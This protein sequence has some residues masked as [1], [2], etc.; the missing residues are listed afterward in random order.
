MINLKRPLVFILAGLLATPLFGQRTIADFKL[1]DVV[2]DK[3]VALTDF[4]QQRGLV[5]IFTGNECP[6]DAH[7]RNRLRA[8]IQNYGERVSFLLIN[9]YTEPDEDTGSMKAAFAGWQLTAPYLADKE[10]VAL[11]ACGAGRSPEA[12]VLTPAGRG[13]KIFYQGAIDDSPQTEEAVTARFLEDALN[14]LLGG[15]PAPAGS[16]AVGCTI[17]KKMK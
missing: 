11:A 3:T 14:A 5:L 1:P 17:R 8:L 9:S 4:A 7:Y 15:K 2:S 13:F 10:Q 16:R 6:F 12:V